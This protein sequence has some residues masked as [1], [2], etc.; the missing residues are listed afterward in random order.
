MRRR[1]KAPV[2]A[3]VLIALVFA[4]ALLTLAAVA[5]ERG[6]RSVSIPKGS[7]IEKYAVDADYADAYASEI[8]ESLFPNREALDRSAFLRCTIAGATDE[9]IV[10]TGESPGLVYYLSYLRG[11]AGSSR[12]LIVSTVVRYENWKGRLYFAFV[13]PLHRVLVPFMVSAMVRRAEAEK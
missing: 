12:N 10:Y 7:L 9:E 1:S 11:H 8:S 6:V 2:I 4:V 5:R 3:L 13:R